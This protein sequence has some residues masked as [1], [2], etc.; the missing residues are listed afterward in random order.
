M[1]GQESPEKKASSCSPSPAEN[2]SCSAVE[3]GSDGA[4]NK[5]TSIKEEEEEKLSL[6]TWNVDGLDGE[7]QPERAR[8]LCS[9]LISYSADVV[10]L[11]EIVQP[12]MRFMHRRLAD[13]YTFIKGGEEGYFTMML[14]KKSRLTLLN[15]EIVIFPNTHMGRNL[16]IAQVMFRG[17][18]LLL[19]TSHFESCKSGSAERMRQLRLVM[20]RMSE[21]PDD[22]TVLFGGDT[23]LRDYEVATVGLPSSV[24]DLWEQLGEPEKCRYTWDTQA[25]TNKDI[26][27]KCHFRFDRV[28]L[29]RASRDGVPRLDPHSM[30]L[31]GLEILKCGLFT[32]DHW[33]IYSK[34]SVE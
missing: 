18:K 9:Y 14:L 19:M 24:C 34:F 12:Y 8:S 30:A 27:F 25:N 29:R 11:Q 4:D 16:L 7:D 23:N 3:T 26:P 13:T 10:L 15:S 33:G 31:I 17:Q 6:I 22:E 28:Y 21:A 5:T 2:R 1:E 20:K 32:S